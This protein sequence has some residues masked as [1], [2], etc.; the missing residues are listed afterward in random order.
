MRP[1]AAVLASCHGLVS[2]SPLANARTTGAHPAACTATIRGVFAP[3][4]PSP[5]SS[6]SA[7]RMPI[8][9]T[10]PPVGQTM[11][12]GTR[13]PSCSAI[14]SPIVFFPSS[15]YGSLSVETSW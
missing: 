9:P 3:I 13:Q 5:A 14:S 11:T 6:A 4:Q 15:R 8:R 1:N 10:P 12:S 2:C 7:L